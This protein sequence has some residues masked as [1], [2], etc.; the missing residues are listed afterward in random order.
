LEVNFRL[1]PKLKVGCVFVVVSSFVWLLD[2]EAL[3][4]IICSR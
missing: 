1:S 4:G 2:L 3:G